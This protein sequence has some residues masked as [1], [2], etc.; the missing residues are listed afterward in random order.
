MYNSNQAAFVE[1][2]KLEAGSKVRLVR[3]WHK[4]EQGFDFG[5]S[6]MPINLMVGR[7]FK[8]VSINE[9]SITLGI[10]DSLGQTECLKA[11]YFALEVIK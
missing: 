3:T 10:V 4:G 7:I 8:V 11:P 9:T 5:K 2:S 6:G 1:K